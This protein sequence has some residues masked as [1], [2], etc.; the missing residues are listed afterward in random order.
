MRLLVVRALNYATNH[1]VAHVPS[2]G[3]RHWW[4][5]RVLGIQLADG[6]AVHLGCYVWFYGPGAIRRGGARIGRNTRINRGCTLDL[7]G[8]LTV[9]DNVSVSLNVTILTASHD[10]NDPGFEVEDRPVTIEDH[11]WI[12]AGATVLPGVTLGHGSVVAAGTVVTRDVTP[13]AIVGG[14]P[15]RPI[16]V[17][18][19]AATGYELDAAR[20]LF[21]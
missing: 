6:A 15:A 9:G 20:P 19:A 16:G 1:I 14:V 4:Y 18:D 2:F 11:V 8:G 5:R 17:R 21:E 10:V 7:R 12:G 3:V 13:L